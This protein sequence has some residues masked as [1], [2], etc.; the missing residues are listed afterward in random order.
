M[1]DS[2]IATEGLA[3]ASL[4]SASTEADTGCPGRFSHPPIAFLARGNRPPEE[5]TKQSQLGHK[6]SYFNN[7]VAGDRHL[8]GTLLTDKTFAIQRRCCSRV[9][10]AAVPVPKE[11]SAS[12]GSRRWLSIAE[13][14]TTGKLRN[15][16]NWNINQTISIT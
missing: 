1:T 11:P 9:G 14:T 4:L 2:G 16:A 15:K 8:C 12:N 6:E 13:P 10:H 7:L 3:R 5:I